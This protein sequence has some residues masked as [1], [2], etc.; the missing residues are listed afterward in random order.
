MLSEQ[1]VREL[2]IRWYFLALS[3]RADGVE[4]TAPIFSKAHAFIKVLGLPCDIGCG[5][6]SEDGLKKYAKILLE[7]WIAFSANDDT[8][9]VNEWLS[10]NV[11][12]DFEN[13]I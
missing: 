12:I 10:A 6:K 7:K 1:R 3:S 5:R 8:V 2:A 9:S 13:H 4:K 11:N